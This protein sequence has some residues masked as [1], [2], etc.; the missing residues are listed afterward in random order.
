MFGDDTGPLQ[1]EINVK[2]RPAGKPRCCEQLK[3]SMRHET[4]PETIDVDRS[5]LVEGLLAGNQAEVPTDVAFDRLSK[6]TGKFL[7]MSSAVAS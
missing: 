6:S 7:P 4:S 2:F 5:R 1:L 3:I